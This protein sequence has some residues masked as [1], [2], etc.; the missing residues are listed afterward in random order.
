MST[1]DDILGMAGM[2]PSGRRKK[3]DDTSSTLAKLLEQAVAAEKR[4]M[5]QVSALEDRIDVLKRKAQNNI[6]RA[7]NRGLADGVCVFAFVDDRNATALA[8]TELRLV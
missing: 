1:I 3:P 2:D 4:A 8:S 5:K 7:Y 6:D